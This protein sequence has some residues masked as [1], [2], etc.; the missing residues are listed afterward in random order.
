MAS[1]TVVLEFVIIVIT[2]LFYPLP[3]ITHGLSEGDG[4]S[5]EKAIMHLEK[6]KMLILEDSHNC[7]FSSTASEIFQLCDLLR[8]PCCSEYS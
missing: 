6:P 7:V 4:S 5:Y 2:P 3:S 8:K 1:L